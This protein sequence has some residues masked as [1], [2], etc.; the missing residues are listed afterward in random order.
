MNSKFAEKR[1]AHL[2]QA[3]SGVGLPAHSLVT[4]MGE[5]DEISRD[6]DLFNLKIPNQESGQ[7]GVR[8]NGLGIMWIVGHEPGADPVDIRKV[9]SVNQIVD[10]LLSFAQNTLSIHLMR[11]VA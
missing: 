3:L 4:F 8:M 7:Y 10:I 5:E 2:C 9:T 6:V 11:A 1:L